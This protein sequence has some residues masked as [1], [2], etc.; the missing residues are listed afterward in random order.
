[1][2]ILIGDRSKHYLL[3]LPRE[4]RTPERKLV[5]RIQAGTEAFQADIP[6]SI[7]SQSLA[8]MF[9]A[10]RDLEQ[11]Q[12]GEFTLISC[13]QEIWMTLTGDGNGR[14][15]AHCTL[16]DISCSHAQMRFDIELNEE[17]L[18]AIHTEL[19]QVLAQIGVR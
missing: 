2:S 15:A 1:M 16:R 10:V 5:F 7:D 17:Q 6:A 8:D 3:L 13:Q 18:H 19:Q 14:F 9:N 4:P 12:V 11:R